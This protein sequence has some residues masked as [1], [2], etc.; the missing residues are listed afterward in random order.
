M[1]YFTDA[2]NLDDEYWGEGLENIDEESIS[3]KKEI[4]LQNSGLDEDQ[5]KTILGLAH[6]NPLELYRE[7][8]SDY[9]ITEGVCRVLDR[10]DEDTEISVESDYIEQE[11][12]RMT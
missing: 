8:E 1:E 11:L 3:Q 6:G 5:A 2:T 10:V 7:A 9:S 12:E 4:I